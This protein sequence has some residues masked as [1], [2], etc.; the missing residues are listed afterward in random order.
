[1]VDKNLNW[2]DRGRK[3]RLHRP[4][5]IGLTHM[6]S[7]WFYGIFSSFSEND[8]ELFSRFISRLLVGSADHIEY[9]Q[10]VRKFYR[11]VTDFRR[12]A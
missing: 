7:I 5:R 4:D 12:L 11:I 8:L 6:A 9:E 10:D 2:P 1:M 3:A